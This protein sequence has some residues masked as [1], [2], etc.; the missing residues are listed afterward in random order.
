MAKKAEFEIYEGFTKRK[1]KYLVF[2]KTVKA[3]DEIVEA[4]KKF[5]KCSIGHLRFTLGYIVDDDLY[6]TYPPLL[7][8][9]QVLVVTYVR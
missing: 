5:F 9:T 2:T 1:K 3:T 4:S 6:L 8:A 7:G